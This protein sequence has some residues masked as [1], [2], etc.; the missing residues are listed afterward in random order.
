MNNTSSNKTQESTFEEIEHTADWALRV[1]GKTA[2][3]LFR[4]AAF[5]MLQLIQAKPESTRSKKRNIELEAFDNESLLVTWLEELLFHI[6]TR[7]VT[8]L[9][10]HIEHLDETH[11]SAVLEETPLVDLKKEI[12]AVTYHNLEIISTEEGLETTVVFDV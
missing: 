8:F 6:E 10:I 12:K 5:G 1:R 9:N 4:N 2:P 3:A 11:L 7:N